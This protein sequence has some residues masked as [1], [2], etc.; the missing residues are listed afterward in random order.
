MNKRIIKTIGAYRI[1]EMQ[2]DMYDLEYLKGDQFNPKHFEEFGFASTNEQANAERE[3]ERLVESVG[4]YG[5]ALERWNPEVGFGWTHVDS[6]WGFVGQYNETVEQFNH[7][8]VNELLNI[9]KENV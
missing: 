1:I 2:D 3:F 5:Y 7:Y 4:V 8:I 9:A 6:C